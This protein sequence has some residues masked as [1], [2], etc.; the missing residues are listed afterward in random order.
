MSHLTYLRLA[1]T[2][3]TFHQLTGLTKAE[4]DALISR[5]S[6][7]WAKIDGQKQHH[8]R[9][10]H[11][12]TWEDKVLCALMYYRTY[13]TH[14]FL[15][16]LFSL[17]NA[18]ICRWL[19]RVE[20]VLAKSVCIKKDRSMTP[21]KILKLIADVTE[22]PTQKPEKKQKKSYSGKK[23]RHT[24][25]TEI[26]VEPTGRIYTVSHTYKGRTHDFS[27]RKQEK[28][29][30][31]HA[32][33]YADSGYQG[34]QKRTS[35]VTI[36]IKKKRGMALSDEDKR[37]NQRL[38]SVRVVVEHVI[39]RLKVFKILGNVYRNFQRKYHMRF[40]IIAGLVN[41]KAGF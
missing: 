13:V 16:Y 28:P 5:T 30:P 40:N 37:H 23:K 21:E 8:G 12:P 3:N 14:T 29:L 26:V 10:S 20:P 2:P 33:K 18:N 19:K 34:W 31:D 1:K 11:L 6:A 17:H 35:N 24:L 4:F 38:A 27:I 32:I 15:G 36:P 25:K 22:Q 9:D 41:M 7:Q 39:R